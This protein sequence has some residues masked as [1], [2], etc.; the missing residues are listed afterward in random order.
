MLSRNTGALDG[1]DTPWDG[2]TFAFIGKITQGFISSVL[3]PNTAFQ[4]MLN[5]RAQ[6]NKNIITHLEELGDQGLPPLYNRR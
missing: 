4:T 3:L 6:S 2:S 5:I 1:R